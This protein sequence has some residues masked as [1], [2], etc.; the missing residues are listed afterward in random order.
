MPIS[1]GTYTQGGGVLKIPDIVLLDH[2][3]GLCWE[4]RETKAILPFWAGASS[5]LFVKR[6]GGA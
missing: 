6:R 1:A 4:A 5:V 2:P 3:L